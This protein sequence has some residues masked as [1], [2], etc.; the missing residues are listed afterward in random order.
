MTVAEPKP[1]KEADEIVAAILDPESRGELYP[2]YHRLRELAPVHPDERLLGRRA[3]IISRFQDADRLLRDL[4][5]ESNRSALEIFDTGPSGVAF[6]ET[7]SKLLLYLDPPDH[8]RIR[9]LVT[10]AFT[11]RSS[12]SWARTSAVRMGT[13][14]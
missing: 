12:N 11:P 8:D 13:A 9:G 10:R 2:L 5:L 3:W 6:Y 4:R 7:M 14:A 1:S